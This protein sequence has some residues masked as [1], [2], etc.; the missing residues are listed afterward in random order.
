MI[1]LK[2]LSRQSPGG[3]EEDHR[4]LKIMFGPQG[5]DQVQV[6]SFAAL[7]FARFIA[8]FPMH[9]ILPI[10]FSPPVFNHITL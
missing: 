7:A 1:C 4:K 10:C 5:I 6:I 9:D 8:Q 3:T 2:V